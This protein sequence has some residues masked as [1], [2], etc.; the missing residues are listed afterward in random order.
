MRFRVA[1]QPLDL[2]VKALPKRALKCWVALDPPAASLPEKAT[3]VDHPQR[4]RIRFPFAFAGLAAMCNPVAHGVP[5]RP[6]IQ[7]PQPLKVMQIIK[8]EFGDPRRK[9]VRRP[10]KMA[11]SIQ[12]L[13][14]AAPKFR[15]AI[16]LTTRREEMPQRLPPAPRESR[17]AF[18][19]RLRSGCSPPAVATLSP[20]LPRRQMTQRMIKSQ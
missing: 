16:A 18:R 15:P 13:E 11:L 4:K 19:L 6:I 17:C 8:P 12:E 9:P 10:P 2:N 3:P 20:Q 1:R 5:C 7:G 14:A